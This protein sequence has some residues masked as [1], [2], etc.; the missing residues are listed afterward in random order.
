MHG[1]YNYWTVSV[2]DSGS[3]SWLHGGGQQQR[4]DIGVDQPLESK[5]SCLY[6]LGS[7]SHL[8]L[9]FA[10]QHSKNTHSCCC[11]PLGCRVHPS[12]VQNHHSASP[13]VCRYRNCI[14]ILRPFFWCFGSTRRFTSSVADRSPNVAARLPTPASTGTWESNAVS[15]C[16]FLGS[17]GTASSPYQF[18][19]SL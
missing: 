18:A 10:V 6:M 5:N 16:S 13:H 1:V 4:R 8:C 11:H 19:S 7:G 15:V 3:G 9:D 12:I 2:G 17:F 14:P